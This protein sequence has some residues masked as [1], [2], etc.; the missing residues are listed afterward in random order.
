M[1]MVQ[2]RSP[3]ELLQDCQTKYYAMKNW[4]K[5]TVKQRH[6]LFKAVPSRPIAPQAM[7]CNLMWS[8]VQSCRVMSCYLVI[9]ISC[10][11]VRV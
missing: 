5:R 3:K 6:D 1:T 2:G 7:S 4:L 10:T 11:A 9:V 8:H